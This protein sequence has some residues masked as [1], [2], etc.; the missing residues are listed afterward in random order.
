MEANKESGKMKQTKNHSIT[1][2][3][4]L[5]FLNNQRERIPLTLIVG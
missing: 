5:P 1:S 3:D 2:R 4:F